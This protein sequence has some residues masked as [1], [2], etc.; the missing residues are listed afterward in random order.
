MGPFPNTK[1]GWQQDCLIL[2]NSA[3]RRAYFITPFELLFS[4]SWFFIVWNPKNKKI[5]KIKIKTKKWKKQ[6]QI[7]INIKIQIDDEIRK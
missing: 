6:I 4:F 5:K 1:N 7:K 2:I 3:N